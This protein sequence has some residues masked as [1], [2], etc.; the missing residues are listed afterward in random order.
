M[1][2][3]RKAGNL[4]GLRDTTILLQQCPT[5]PHATYVILYSYRFSQFTLAFAVPIACIPTALAL[6]KYTY[7]RL[8]NSC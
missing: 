8:P 7:D 1:P 5:G 2:V 3:G 6:L 4:R